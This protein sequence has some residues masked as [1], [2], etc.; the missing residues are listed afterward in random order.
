MKDKL[1]SGEGR[2]SHLQIAAFGKGMYKLQEK[3]EYLPAQ[4]EKEKQKK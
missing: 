3:G 4:M 2:F 1:H